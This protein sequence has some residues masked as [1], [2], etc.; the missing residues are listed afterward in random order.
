MITDKIKNK[1]LNS[2]DINRKFDREV[3]DSIDIVKKKQ[4]DYIH[5]LLCLQFDRKIA[6]TLTDNYIVDIREA[7]V[8]ELTDTIDKLKTITSEDAEPI[9]LVNEKIITLEKLREQVKGVTDGRPEQV[10]PGK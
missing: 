4:I 3:N 1:A 7:L 6:S 9:K 8:E 10:S 5:A 2:F